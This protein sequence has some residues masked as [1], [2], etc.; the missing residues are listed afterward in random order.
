MDRDGKR[1]AFRPKIPGSINGRDP[2]RRTEA[3]GL[4]DSDG[5]VHRLVKGDSRK[6]SR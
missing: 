2:V 5:D 4:E 1:G 6:E 3:A